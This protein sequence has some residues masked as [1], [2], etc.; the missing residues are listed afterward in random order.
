MPDSPSAAARVP[1]SRDEL[2]AALAARNGENNQHV[3][4]ATR[5]GVAGAGGLG[6]NVAV[7]LARM[8]VGRLTVADFDAVEPTNLNRQH[9]TMADLGRPKVAAL[10]EQ[11]AAINPYARV[12]AREVRVDSSNVVELFGDCNVVCECFDRADQKALLV[13]AVCTLLPN[14]P[15]VCGSGMAG[16][17]PGNDVRCRRR[18]G[19]VYV[20]GDETSDAGAGLP[21]LAPRVA[22]CAAQ[23]ATQ[24][25]R[26]LL[27]LPDDA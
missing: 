14:T 3:F 25:A 22:L 17:G 23:Q 24:V 4:A 7:L 21:L 11:L 2:F 1:L 10:A 26:L 13:E 8:G 20:C 15:L 19:G 6:S 27:D 5:V 16:T 18:F 12:D 9:Y